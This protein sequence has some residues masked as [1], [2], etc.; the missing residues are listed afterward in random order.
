MG[1]VRGGDKSGKKIYPLGSGDEDE[2]LLRIIGTV[3]GTADRDHR[4][5]SETDSEETLRENLEGL[6]KMKTA[7]RKDP[8]AGS[9]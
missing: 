1:W 7:L 2:R 6:E 9:R 3:D 8:A 4:S 5:S